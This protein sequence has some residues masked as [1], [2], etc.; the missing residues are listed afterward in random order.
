MRKRTLA[1]TALTLA[2]TLAS[3]AAIAGCGGKSTS[4]SHGTSTPTTG[5]H[6][7]PSKAPAY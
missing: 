2:A 3:T 6:K 4:S 7:K 1:T 5:T